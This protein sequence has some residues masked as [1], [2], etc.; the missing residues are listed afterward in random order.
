MLLWLLLLLLA[1]PLAW[2]RPDAEAAAWERTVDRVSAAVVSI[3]VTATRSFDT[4]S[5][6]NS[7]ATGF[8]VDAE[9]GLV[10][11]N[12]HVVGP[13]PVK[14]RAV[15][16]NNEEI[17]LVPVYRDPVH[18]FGFFRFDPKAVRFMQLSELKL[19]PEK[20]RVGAEIRVIGNDAGEK[21]SI[22]AGT[23][24]RLD[25]EAPSYGRYR[26]NDFNTFYYQAASGTSGGSSGSPVVDRDGDVIALNAGSRR[27]AAS[28]YFLPL[29]RVARALERIRQGQP[30]SRGT[31]QATLVHRTYDEL[32]RLGLR[33]ETEA[34]VRAARPQGTGLLVF[35][36]IVPQG[37]A[38]D[39]LALGDVLRSLDGRPIHDFIEL[40]SVLDE[41]VGKEVQVGVERGGAALSFPVLVQDLHEITPSS[42]VEVGDV[43][44]NELSYQQA[45]HGPVPTGG[46]YVSASGYM[47]QSAGVSA[48]AVITAIG[49]EAIYS[50]E[51]AWQALL[52]LPDGA[53][54]PLRWYDLSAPR[55]ERTGVMTMDRRWF[56]MRRCAWEAATGSWPCEE[57]AA[58]PPAPP[59]P[60]VST[61]IPRARKAVERK[62]A[63]SL[64][65]VNFRVPYRVEGTYGTSFQGNGLVVDAE[66]GLVL[67]DRDT[68]PNA[69]GDATITFAGSVEV[70]ARLLHVHPLHNLA[71][72]QYDPAAVGQTPVRAARLDD[73]PLRSG[74]RVWHVGLDRRASVVSS[75]TRV[76]RVE[77]L[78]LPLPSPPFFRD[79]NLETIILRDAARAG[80]G[81][82]ADRRGR[83]H[84]LWASFVDLSGEEP[85]AFFRGL[86]GGLFLPSTEALIAGRTPGHRALGCEL[87]ELTLVEARRRGL[88]EE[89]ARAL[90]QAGG[91]DRRAFMIKRLWADAPAREQLR[92]GDIL[93]EV[94][95]QPAVSLLA[96]ERASEAERVRLRLA[97]L[98]Q[99]QEVEVRT[100]DRQGMALDHVVSW[101]GA[102]LH[103][104]H[105]AVPSQRGLSPTGVYVAWFWYGSP[106]AQ[107]GLRATRRVLEVD[108]QPTPDL[109]SFLEAVRGR[110]QGSVRLKTEDLDGRTELI[111]LEQ[112]PVWWPTWE[113]RRGPDGWTRGE[114]GGD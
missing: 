70:P 23:L 103:P 42:F 38:W 9:R 49:E 35:D 50:L 86:P 72:L 33:A 76:D 47:L 98:G 34:A 8:I 17:D 10:L 58:P 4:E 89:A 6:G 93:L 25:R 67:V 101:A 79:S 26:Y 28:S 77:P 36:G 99:V 44:L 83:V 113:L 108:G 109:A 60:P 82:L 41:S 112:D 95:G 48:R 19:A 107:Y 13:G 24:A 16:L 45:R 20:A 90:E 30:V 65:G 43:L 80:G 92:E 7:V 73:R 11:T 53:R 78:A 1:S 81:V 71:W 88:P 96:I 15:F 31:I 68:V 102:L 63:P 64:V 52:A 94:E 54:V 85:R 29:E 51:D 3:R 100:L 56:P 104:V 12:R 91:L 105:E 22:L 21:I 18:D 69:M 2:A 66:Q 37:P 27:N 46:A 74:D 106:A 32:R 87:E 39:D 59:A 110:P 55:A 5:A 111:T 62:L 40:E 57:A 114:L 14:A 75:R 84:A 61:T 97:R